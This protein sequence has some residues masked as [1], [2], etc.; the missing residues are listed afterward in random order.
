MY[1]RRKCQECRLK[2]CLS[3]GMR[4]ECKQTILLSY[5]ELGL[6]F[7]KYWT[8]NSLHCSRETSSLLYRKIVSWCIRSECAKFL[9]AWQFCI[10]DHFQ[11]VGSEFD[12][13]VERSWQPPDRWV[14]DIWCHCNQQLHTSL[15]KRHEM[16]TLLQTF[17]GSHSSSFEKNGW[18]NNFSNIFIILMWKNTLI[19]P[20]CTINSKSV[21]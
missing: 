20:T 8:H 12:I 18:L 11:G 14:S 21:L 13:S 10:T 1:M 3:V 2:K 16:L 15:L 9:S 7:P 19:S 5:W 6:G 17:A 4:P